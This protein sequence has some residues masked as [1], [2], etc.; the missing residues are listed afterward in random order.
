MRILVMFDLPVTTAAGRRE[1]FLFRKF[2]IKSGFL[3]LQE[4]IY[5][6]IAQNST[7]AD[8][9]VDNI[10]KNKPSAGLVQVLKVTEKQYSKMEYIVGESISDVLNTDERMVIL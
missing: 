2:L 3:M 5:C 1:Y 6:K 10:K 4:S 7:M 9:I 8:S